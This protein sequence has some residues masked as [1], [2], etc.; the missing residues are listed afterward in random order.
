MFGAFSITCASCA[1]RWREEVPRAASCLWEKCYVKLTG[2]ASWVTTYKHLL[3]PQHIQLCQKW[4][5]RKSRTLCWYTC[6]TC[7]FFWQRRNNSWVS[8]WVQASVVSHQNQESD[9][10]PFFSHFSF[11][12]SCLTSRTHLCSVCWFSPHLYPGTNWTCPRTR[13]FWDTLAPTTLPLCF[14]VLI[15][16]LSC[17]WNHS[18]VLLGST[19]APVKLHTRWDVTILFVFCIRFVKVA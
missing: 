17:C 18:V 5:H 12:F 7:S 9:L 16:H 1:Y 3:A 11:F 6:S 8:R 15:L 10:F 19:P 13:A 2:S 4:P 14:S